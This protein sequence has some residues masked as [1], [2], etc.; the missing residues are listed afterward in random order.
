M[1]PARYESPT[2][3][4]TCPPRYYHDQHMGVPRQDLRDGLYNYLMRVPEREAW[5][6]EFQDRTKGIQ[7]HLLRLLSSPCQMNITPSTS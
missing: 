1:R 3:G 6:H 7:K 2:K 4:V 5:E